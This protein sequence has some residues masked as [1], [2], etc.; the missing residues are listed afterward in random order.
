MGRESFTQNMMAAGKLATLA[1]SLREKRIHA[2]FRLAAFFGPAAH[3]LAYC[4][5][6]PR[7]LDTM[8]LFHVPI[9]EY[10]GTD[11]GPTVH[12]R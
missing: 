9:K 5:S 10:L 11:V 4:F 12:L 6:I 8:R 7:L 3:E 2:T 1:K